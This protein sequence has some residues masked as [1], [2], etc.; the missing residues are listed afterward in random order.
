MAPCDRKRLAASCPTTPDVAF[1]KAA[2]PSTTARAGLIQSA[3][4]PARMAQAEAELRRH[5]KR[6]LFAQAADLAAELAR[7][8]K[9]IQD[10][11]Q[12]LPACSGAELS[13]LLDCSAA[14][15]GAIS[16]SSRCSQ[17]L[18]SF[19]GASPKSRLSGDARSTEGVLHGTAFQAACTPLVDRGLE[20][21][22]GQLSMP[23]AVTLSRE[24]SPDLASMPPRIQRIAQVHPL[25][26]EGVFLDSASQAQ[27]HDREVSLQ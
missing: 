3:K 11:L 19:V 24:A 17:G 6:Q 21:E 2:Q 22:A 7:L 26:S 20:D 10:R 9:R 12:Q 4:A 23:Q 16:L 27:C 14:D 5:A 25:C 1:L 13:Q 8:R 18:D 15:S